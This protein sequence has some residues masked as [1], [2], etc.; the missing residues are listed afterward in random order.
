MD[1]QRKWWITQTKKIK[2]KISRQ[3]LSTFYNDQ[4]NDKK[5]IALYY[6]EHTSNIT[7]KIFNHY[8]YT[9]AHKTNN[10]VAINLKGHNTDNTESGI[11]KITCNDCTKFYIG[12]TGR[13]FSQRFK[14]HTQEIK[15]AKKNAK[16]NYAKHMIDEKHTYTDLESNLQIMHAGKKSNYIERKEEYEIYKER[17]NPMLLNDKINTKTNKIF[18]FIESLK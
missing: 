5:H 6:N 3:D 12:Y 15:Y 13:T 10:T 11:Y 2:N 1:T 7:K 4:K 14:E 18:D 16:S 9:L 8:G 17:R